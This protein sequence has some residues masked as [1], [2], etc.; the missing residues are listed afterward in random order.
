MSAIIFQYA[1]SFLLIITNSFEMITKYTGILLSMCSLLTVLGIFRHRRKFPNIE[2][3]YKTLGYPVTP[4]LFCVLIVWSIVY[5]VYEDYTM[6]A[7]GEQ[8]VMWMT[9]MSAF[10]LISGII[11]YFINTIIIKKHINEK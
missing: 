8:P 6:F 3:K 2:R 5:L 1:I 7:K 11:V 9:L 4:I 10:T